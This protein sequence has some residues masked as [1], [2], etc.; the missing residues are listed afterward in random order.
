MY[1][2]LTSTS[3]A[4]Q[5]KLMYTSVELFFLCDYYF[6]SFPLLI[7]DYIYEA[8][9]FYSFYLSTKNTSEFYSFHSLRMKHLVRYV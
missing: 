5:F 7:D 8:E 3:D 9:I 2:C 4:S 1:F 6:R